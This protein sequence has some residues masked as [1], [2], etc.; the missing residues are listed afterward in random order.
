MVAIVLSPYLLIAIDETSF[1]FFRTKIVKL[2]LIFL[3]KKLKINK[4]DIFGHWC[5]YTVSNCIHLQQRSFSSINLIWK[6]VIEIETESVYWDFIA[7]MKKLKS[8][9]AK[10]TNVHNN[11]RHSSVYLDCCV[12]DLEFLKNS[13]SSSFKLT[14]KSLWM[15]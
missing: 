12:F 6:D 15:A 11:K 3:R 4:D 7:S 2:W 13:I 14:T 9:C 8:F 5:E 10:T 1:I